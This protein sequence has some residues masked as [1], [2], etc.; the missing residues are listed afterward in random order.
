MVY[1]IQKGG[2]DR[3]VYCAVVVQYDCNNICI[4]GGGGQINDD[5]LGRKSDV[6]NEYLVKAK[7]H[8]H[9]QNADDDEDMFSPRRPTRHRRRVKG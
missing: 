8:P 4:T 5:W 9:T 6:V 1:S 2:Q 3:G 7:L